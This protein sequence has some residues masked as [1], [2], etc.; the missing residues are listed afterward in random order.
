MEFVNWTGI[1]VETA[2]EK[3]VV[4][5]KDSIGLPFRVD[6]MPGSFKIKTPYLPSAPSSDCRK[7]DPSR[8]IYRIDV[9]RDGISRSQKT[10]NPAD[11]SSLYVNKDVIPDSTS[12]G[13]VGY[14]SLDDPREGYIIMEGMVKVIGPRELGG[15]MGTVEFSGV[16]SVETAEIVHMKKATL[17]VMGR[18]ITE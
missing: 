2:M 3:L 17:R 7:I 10:F 13:E 4:E 1:L 18:K 5:L 6:Q 15:R 12:E 16:I 8:V 14:K 9:S 11:I